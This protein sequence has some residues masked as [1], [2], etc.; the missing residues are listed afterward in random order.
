MTLRIR[1]ARE[2]AGLSQRALAER[3]GTSQPTISAYESGRKVPE[4]ATLERL[5]RAAG[6]RPSR[7]LAERR[8]AVV[9][10]V[11]AHHGRRVWVFGSVARSEDQPTSDVDLLVEFDD[12]VT[13]TDLDRIT[14]DVEAILGVEVDVVGSGGL[15]AGD[16]HITAQARLL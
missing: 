2:N 8:A 5:L 13:F 9:E 6:V 14:D 11:R 3:A 12:G 7:P 4:Q 15:R 1:R 16:D 10:A